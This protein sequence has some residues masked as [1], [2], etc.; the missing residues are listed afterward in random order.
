MAAEW[1]ELTEGYSLTYIYGAGPKGQREFAKVGSDCTP[2]PEM[3]ELMELPNLGDTMVD[4]VNG[5]SDV[6]GCV[7]KDTVYSY[8]NPTTTVIKA[9]C[10]YD[11]D[12]SDQEGLSSPGDLPRNLSLSPTFSLQKVGKGN[13]FAEAAYFT[14]PSR[15][16]DGSE[17]VG[18]PTRV[19]DV[20]TDSDYP[21]SLPV[22]SIGG[23][24][25]IQR[26]VKNLDTQVNNI[27]ACVGLTNVD[28]FYGFAPDTV[29]YAGA[30]TTE[31]VNFQ[32]VKRW[33]ITHKF[34]IS[35]KSSGYPP[36][37]EG[38]EPPPFGVGGHNYF[39]RPDAFQWELLYLKR[40]DG[41]ITLTNPREDI[42]EILGLNADI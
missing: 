26:V 20:V 21:V 34:I 11:A 27:V 13:L 15:N 4:R 2:T 5:D 30:D 33:K 31:F 16:V 22:P 9:T 3:G 23:T 6:I 41:S 37:G 32:G 8:P 42:A 40:A 14:G 29:M 17:L 24:L 7:M 38:G 1:V 36:V 10:N 39:W 28:E 35:M 25:S 19:I 12:H 18:G